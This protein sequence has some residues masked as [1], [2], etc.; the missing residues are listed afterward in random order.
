MLSLLQEV[1]KAIPIKYESTNNFSTTRLSNGTGSS[2]TSLCSSKKTNSTEVNSGQL[3]QVLDKRDPRRI[4]SFR[5]EICDLSVSENLEKLCDH[6]FKL[7]ASKLKARKLESISS[8]GQSGDMSNLG[9]QDDVIDSNL[10]MTVSSLS[11]HEDFGSQDIS[12]PGF[13]DVFHGLLN[14][15]Q[16]ENLLKKDGEF[17]IRQIIQDEALILS[18]RLY[19]NYLN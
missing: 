16:T 13:G 10:S 5:M 14:K 17:L 2:S 12:I 6:I 4:E 15:S 19:N 1:P 18:L 11:T 7:E 9:S 3:G 8:H